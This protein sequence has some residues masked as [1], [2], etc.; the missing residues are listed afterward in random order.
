MFK[1]ILV[2]TVGVIAGYVISALLW[3]EEVRGQEN[4]NIHLLAEIARL[5]KQLNI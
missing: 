3:G 2:G 5:N 1:Y 4:E